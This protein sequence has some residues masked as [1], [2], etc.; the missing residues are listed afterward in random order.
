MRYLWFLVFILFSFT[1]FSWGWRNGFDGDWKKDWKVLEERKWGMENLE[2]L[3]EKGNQFV[4]VYYPKGS[5]SPNVTKFVGAPVGGAQFIN[6]LGSFDSL[7]LS[8]SF[9]FKK[10]FQYRLG[11]KLPGLYGGMGNS[12]GNIPNGYDGFST[13]FMWRKN[14]EGEL[15]AYLPSSKE[16][17]TSLGKGSWFFKS[18]EW[19]K[20]Q[21]K[22]KLNEAGKE[23]GEIRIWL[24]HQLVYQQKGL[25]FRKTD[26]LKINGIFFSTFFGGND[27]TW[28]S[29]EDTYIDFDNFEASEDYIK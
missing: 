1:F 24:D 25:E 10:D 23:N 28:A 26:S 14:G 19:H 2:I 29:P 22:L 12:G 27:S 20:L 13:R 21:H 9:R 16:W 6:Y 4:R 17:G 11:G 15:Y 5:A 8:Y 7:Y 3:K 18:G